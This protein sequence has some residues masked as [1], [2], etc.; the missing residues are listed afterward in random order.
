MWLQKS[1]QPP[2][3]I[4]S[5]VWV[6]FRIIQ[7]NQLQDFRL[8]KSLPRNWDQGK[9]VGS[10]FHLSQLFVFNYL[11]HRKKNPICWSIFGPLVFSRLWTC[12]PQCLMFVIDHTKLPSFFHQHLYLFYLMAGLLFTT[13]TLVVWATD[14]GASGG[15]TGTTGCDSWAGFDFCEAAWLELEKNTYTLQWRWNILETIC[16]PRIVLRW[17]QGQWWGS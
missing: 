2:A 14:T 10:P 12:N 3:S 8:L 7:T 1:Q 9:W 15:F 13:V 6:A 4:A 11:Q 5:L 16:A 17:E